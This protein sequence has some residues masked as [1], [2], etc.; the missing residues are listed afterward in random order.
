MRYTYAVLAV[1]ALIGGCSSSDSDTPATTLPPETVA[2]TTTTTTPTTTTTA[3]TTT[4][5]TVPTTTTTTAPTTSTEPPPNV[6]ELRENAIDVIVT[7]FEDWEWERVDVI[8]FDEEGTFVIEGQLVWASES[9]Q[10]NTHWESVQLLAEWVGA[11]E[12]PEA[13]VWAFGGPPIVHLTTTS[14]DGNYRY[15]SWT[16]YESFV[17]IVNRRMG[18]DDWKEASDAGFQ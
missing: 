5:T 15:Q 14:D 17:E 2:T 18:M 16:D 7:G 8:Y 12:P 9:R 11:V 3:P 6:D 4:T 10:E 1:V 13:A